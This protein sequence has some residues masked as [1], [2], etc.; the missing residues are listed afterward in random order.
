MHAYRRV[1]QEPELP[2]KELLRPRHREVSAHI[3]FGE[4]KN[5]IKQWI[6]PVIDIPLASIQC[7]SNV[8]KTPATFV[9]S[10]LVHVFIEG[11]LQ[12]IC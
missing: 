1:V 10:A 11:L 8:V 2:R 9:E 5:E 6:G 4:A 3:A 12:D 7:G